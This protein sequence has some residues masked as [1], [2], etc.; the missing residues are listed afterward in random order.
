MP[1]TPET[2]STRT[3]VLAMAGADGSLDTGPLFDVAAACGMSDDQVRLCLRRMTADGTLTPQGGRGRRAAFRL[4]PG[5]SAEVLPE[6]EFLDYALGQDAGRHPWDG[7]WGLV[8]F[9]IPEGE[10][11]QRDRLRR[12]LLYL[13][14]GL[15]PGGLYVSPNPWEDLVSAAAADL[16]V[17][18]H[19]TMARTGR[20]SIGTTTDPAALAADIWPLADVHTGY[21]RF[22]AALRRRLG[23]LDGRPVDPPTVL[24][25][26]LITIVAFAEASGPDPLLP[27]ELVPRA[28][29]AGR[30]ARAL[31]LTAAE[32]YTS[33][34]GADDLPYGL[35][36]LLT[37]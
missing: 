37:T 34:L 31:L 22:E 36:R 20:L 16:G 7:T 1:P 12:Q 8:G 15:V 21:Q 5:A 32:R 9:T 10:R 4:R 30:S 35:R 27:P 17:T 23:R 24:R 11:G 18:G 33:V 28:D 3:L 25:D 26:A 13:G 2:L 14:G 6:L 19:L 29:W